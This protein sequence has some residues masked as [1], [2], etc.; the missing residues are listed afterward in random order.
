[1]KYILSLPPN[2]VD[3][4]HQL[5]S[6]D[7]QQWFV[8]S[9]PNGTRIGSGGG[10]SHALSECRK[11][12]VADGR[13]DEPANVGGTDG[14]AD[15]LAKEKRIIIHAGGLSRRLPSYAPS[16]KIL[17]PLPVFRWSRGQNIQQKLLD[18]Q[19]PLFE[20]IM[21]SAPDHSNTLIT[22]GDV[23]IWNEGPI[24][25]IPAADVVCFGIWTEPAQ[26][27]ASRRVLPRTQPVGQS[28]VHAA[29]ALDG[30]DHRTLQPVRRADR[31]R[32]VAPERQG[33]AGADEEMRLAGCGQYVCEGRSRILRSLQRLRAGTGIDPRNGGRGAQRADHRG[34]R[35][36]QG[37]VLSLRHDERAHR[38]ERGPAESRAQPARDLAPQDKTAPGD[39]RP[40]CD[41]GSAVH[42]G[43]PVPVDREFAHQQDIGSSGRTR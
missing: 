36:G 27:D 24:P 3:T 13:A 10:T 5:E 11:R 37:R 35:A 38:I 2:L 31:H 19:L 39:L 41:N 22:S 8:T 42:G 40:E 16:G 20:K 34:G 14:I 32:R 21:G 1:M 9:D 28:G 29:E 43:Q 6:K 18:L 17:T 23:L 30:K 4:F 26:G 15:W 7:T 25:D 33:R 12:D